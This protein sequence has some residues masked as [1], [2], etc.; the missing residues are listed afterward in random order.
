M[1][2][3]FKISG[4]GCVDEVLSLD[5]DGSDQVSSQENDIQW[6]QRSKRQ[7]REVIE[8]GD[9]VQNSFRE[10]EISNTASVQKQARDRGSNVSAS[11]LDLNFYLELR[12]D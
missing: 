10:S 12:N 2:K 7:R 5:V 1:K 6:P 11:T 3:W 8:S 4:R 9:Q